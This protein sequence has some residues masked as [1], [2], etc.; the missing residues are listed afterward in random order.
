MKLR[1]HVNDDGAWRPLYGHLLQVGRAEKRDEVEDW[2]A[3]FAREVLLAKKWEKP[4]F[5]PG[6]EMSWRVD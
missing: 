5:G 1:Y 2:G 6:V 4:D 3:Q